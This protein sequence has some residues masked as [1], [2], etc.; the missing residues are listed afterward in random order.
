MYCQWLTANGQ[1][2]TGLLRRLV[3]ER[4]PGR[5]AFIARRMPSEAIRVPSVSAAISRA[6][7]CLP[8][9]SV[10]STMLRARIALDSRLRCSWLGRLFCSWLALS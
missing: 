4:A 2:L 1:R 10:S 8:V 3:D 9:S 5:A 7:R 6:S